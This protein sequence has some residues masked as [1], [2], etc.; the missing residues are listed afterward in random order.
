[1][2]EKI[3]VQIREGAANAAIVA[4]DQITMFG[5][6]P[7]SDGSDGSNGSNGSNG[8]DGSDGADGVSPYAVILTNEAH[9]LPATGTAANA[10]TYTGSG[11][12]I[13][14]Y[15][16][17]T[18]LNSV[19]GTPSTG[20][21]K[22]TATATNI[23]AGAESIT[24]NPSVF[25]D[26]TNMTANNATV[27]F[28]VN[29]EG[30][31]TIVKVQTLSKS[32]KGN[33]GAAGANGTNGLNS[34]TVS[35]YN[36]STSNSSAPTAFNGTITYT[37]S[38]G[39]VT[40]DGA[41]NSWT[42]AVPALAA[43]EYAWVRQAAASANTSTDTIAIGEWS[44]AVMHSGIGSDGAS[45]TGAAG[46]SNALVSLFRVSTNGSSAPTPF[47][48]T[49]TYT[50]ATGAVS[51][52][53][54]LQSWTTTVPAV[55]QG[56]FLW[57]RQA[58][59]SSNT[60]TDTIAIGDWSTAVVT[61]A[62]GEDGATGAT[63]GTGPTGATG[64]TGPTGARSFSKYL[65]YSTAVTSAPTF[66]ST[67]VTFSFSTNS[68]SNL[69]SGWS[70]SAPSA[71]PGSG[72]NNYWHIPVTVVEGSPYN[73]L[74]FGSVTRMFGFSGLV[75]FTGTGNNTLTDG[76]N[77]FNYTAID[78]GAITTG[79]I[80][81]D[82]ITTGI[83]RVGGNLTGTV[84]G[85]AV[86]TVTSG[87][88]AGATANQN[89]TATILGGNLTGTVDGTAVST[90]KSGAA[91]GAT[92]QQNDSDKTDGTVGGWTVDPT[93]IFSGTKDV[94]GY[95]AGGITINSGGSIH[96]KQF[97]IDTSG[98]AFFKGALSAASGTFAGALSAATGTFT[99]SLVVNGTALIQGSSASGD[100]IAAKFQNT[101]TTNASGA[102][103][104][105]NSSSN[106][107]HKILMTG[108]TTTNI[109]GTSAFDL[110]ASYQLGLDSSYSTQI[111]KLNGAGLIIP[112]QTANGIIVSGDYAGGMNIIFNDNDG[113]RTVN[114][115]RMH[116]N[117]SMKTFFLDIPANPLTTGT[118]ANRGFSMRKYVAASSSEFEILSVRPATNSLHVTGDIHS[119][120]L[121]DKDST[122]YY[123]HGGHTG[124]SIN[125]AGDIIAYASSD[126]RL[127]DNIKPIENALDKVNK[128]SG[129]TFEWNE[130]SHKE[131]GKKDVGVIA[132]EIEAILPELVENRSSGYKAVDYPKLTALL[133]EA[134]KELSIKLDKCSANK[135]KCNK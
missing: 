3:E 47:T 95:T 81:A 110:N 133:I 63:G 128:I 85:V 56:S 90:V 103:I 49:V 34:A 52:N 74:T 79:T 73:T 55:A 33:T 28:S 107:H 116:V 127:K 16:G 86:G 98:N 25:G 39:G 117:E 112:N 62:A 66:N 21:F 122:G 80:S 35:L 114:S 88:A 6:K 15:K 123:F 45:I 69:P 67:G 106:Y 113:S 83:L 121:V 9:T 40:T 46:N 24:G 14:V 118:Y 7:G 22:V 30:Q 68:F 31:A 99:G 109:N 131:T 27:S 97:Y 23:T 92:A 65:F 105:L 102:G 2:P 5:I 26:H 42:I 126:K 54:N 53:G 1:M 76:T 44:T 77:N 124:T 111:V 94:D 120:R 71:T 29:C 8:E 60:A 75:T 48:G 101:N 134:V 78:G 59:A 51:T 64:G 100:F 82:R 70:A 32:I 50:F 13:D 87:A 11:T 130:I 17:I 125:V 12:T 41:L 58:V 10:A 19:S 72:S 20:Q 132:Q 89:S 119:D 91:S 104:S 108:G 84:N 37:F 57:T 38:T 18:Q 93:A 36:K 96:T 4:R 135:C 61:A 115:A 43:G 129:V